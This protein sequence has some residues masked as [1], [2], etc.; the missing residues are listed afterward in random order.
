M[1][2][3]REDSS[4]SSCREFLFEMKFRGRSHR[5]DFVSTQK[6]HVPAENVSATCLDEKDNSLADYFEYSFRDILYSYDKQYT[7]DK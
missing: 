3:G 4:F 6:V 5:N 2:K 7:Y 1:S